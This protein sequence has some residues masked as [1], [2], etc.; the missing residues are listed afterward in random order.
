[1][2]KNVWGPRLTYGGTG[3]VL[4][5]AVAAFVGFGS[6]WVTT[7]SRLADAVLEA[8]VA[9]YAA[10]CADDAVAGWKEGKHDT[11]VLRKIDAWDTRDKLAKKYVGGLPLAGNADLK[12]R[13]QRRCSSDL[14]AEADEPVTTAAATATTPH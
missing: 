12:D 5:I 4:G 14:M 9:S 10:I 11:A 7:Q 8:K 13:V 3:A 6:G 1:M 2:D